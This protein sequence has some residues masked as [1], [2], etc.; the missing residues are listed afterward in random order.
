MAPFG[1]TVSG[2]PRTAETKLRARR[3]YVTSFTFQKQERRTLETGG[4]SLPHLTAGLQWFDRLDSFDSTAQLEMR[5]AEIVMETMAA[6]LEK[7][8][9]FA[10]H[11]ILIQ[12]TRLPLVFSRLRFGTTIVTPPRLIRNCLRSRVPR[13]IL[14]SAQKRLHCDIYGVLGGTPIAYTCPLL[15]KAWGGHQYVIRFAEDVAASFPSQS[16]ETIQF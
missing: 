9:P 8:N 11:P 7:A 2:P 12:V 4:E 5:S 6:W 15:S 16:E 13:V 1:N 14:T 10:F 3:V